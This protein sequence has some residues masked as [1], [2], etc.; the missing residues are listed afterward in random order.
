MADF[1]IDMEIKQLRKMDIPDEVAFIV[2]HVNNGKVDEIQHYIE[3]H[4]QEQQMIKDELDKLVP[5]EKNLT[6]YN[7]NDSN[8][9]KKDS[10]I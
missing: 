8:D 10:N 5:F 7:N 6:L 1:K 3:M 4:K 9:E 2:A